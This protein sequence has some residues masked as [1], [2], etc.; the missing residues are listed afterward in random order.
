MGRPSRGRPRLELDRR[1]HAQRPAPLG[2]GDADIAR[3][4]LA[5][6]EERALDVVFVALGL[7]YGPG[8][9]FE[10]RSSIRAPGSWDRGGT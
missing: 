1:G 4:L 2:A 6:R 10:P 3:H 5:L 9:L 8:G 7:V